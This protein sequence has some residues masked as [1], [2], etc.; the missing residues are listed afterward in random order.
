MDKLEK[1]VKEVCGNDKVFRVYYETGYSR[2][3]MRIYVGKFFGRLSLRDSDD[4]LRFARVNC[5]SEQQA[6]L[7]R[8][9][10]EVKLMFRGTELKRI[11]KSIQKIEKQKWKKVQFKESKI[12]V[13]K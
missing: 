1:E 3:C 8:D 4:F 11:E 10:E 13:R 2:G 5:T 12:R 6:E 9:L 7:L